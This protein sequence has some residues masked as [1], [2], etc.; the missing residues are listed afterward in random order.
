MQE[1]TPHLPESPQ[2]ETAATIVDGLLCDLAS[3]P[4]ASQQLL[5]YVQG[6]ESME[7]ID[8][9]E[10]HRAALS[11]I[12][13]AFSATSQDRS[14]EASLRVLYRKVHESYLRVLSYSAQ[15]NPSQ[16]NLYED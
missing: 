1:K 2:P 15:L 11:A 8:I 9:L 16:L 14:A 6:D 12:E 13:S 5:A 7:R 4:E 10:R 3:Y